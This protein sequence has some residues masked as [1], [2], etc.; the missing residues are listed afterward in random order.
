MLRAAEFYAGVAE[1]M[2]RADPGWEQETWRVQA[3][4]EQEYLPTVL[5]EPAG[6]AILDCSCG[7][8]PQ[9]IALARLGWRVTATDVDGQSL[10]VARERARPWLIRASLALF[11]VS[12]FMVTVM[13][14][15]ASSA[16]RY[17]LEE[18]LRQPELEAYWLDFTISLLITMAVV[19][20]GEAMLAYEIFTGRVLPRQGLRRHWRSITI[21]AAG[22]S[23]AGG[24]GYA[25]QFSLTYLT[26]L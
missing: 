16:G 20:I 21:I 24:A 13:L 15:M 9:A 18:M 5:G 22:Y 23:L 26:R 8:G 17:S 6:R 11:A 25:L 14:W 1:Y 3:S 12:V 19:L 7:N 2:R 4:H 10:T